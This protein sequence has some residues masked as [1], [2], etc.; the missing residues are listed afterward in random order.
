[1]DWGGFVEG[2]FDDGEVFGMEVVGV[3]VGDEEGVGGCCWF[4]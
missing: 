1:M 3:E 2:V 4:F